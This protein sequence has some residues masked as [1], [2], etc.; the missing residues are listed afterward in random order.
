VEKNQVRRSFTLNL[1]FITGHIGLVLPCKLCL[2]GH[3]T[4][5]FTQAHLADLVA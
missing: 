2:G 3:I 5:S 1:T 4:V